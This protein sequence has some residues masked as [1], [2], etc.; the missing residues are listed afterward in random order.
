MSAS[1]LAPAAP[2]ILTEDDYQRFPD[3]GRRW[4]LIDGEAYVTPAPSLEHQRVSRN[5][6][7]V[8]HEHVRAHQLGEIFYAPVDVYLG[9]TDIAQPDLVFVS[10]ARV[11][12]LSKRGIEGA[13]DLV[14]E[15]LSPSTKHRDLGDKQQMYARH[16]VQ[17]YWIVDPVA[18]SIA[19]LALSGRAYALVA[20]HCC[21]NASPGGGGFE[22]R[23]IAGLTIALGEVFGG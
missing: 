2:I 23:C 7:F 20:T 19:E 18:K 4:E 8:L 15:I 10:A 17:H 11:A 16:G 1:S 13:P 5:L 21:V 3:D 12:I 22:P 9:R 14:I 6:E